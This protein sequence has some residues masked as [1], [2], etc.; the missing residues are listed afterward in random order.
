MEAPEGMGFSKGCYML[1][2]RKFRFLISFVGLLL[3]AFVLCDELFAYNVQDA[4]YQTLQNHPDILS[5]K[6]DS[7]AAEQ[8][9]RV[10]QGGL[11]PSLDVSAGIGRENSNNPATRAARSGTRTMTRREAEAFLQQLVFDG[12]N[13]LST[14]KQR[15]YEFDTSVHRITEI[16]ER[17]A[18]EA[19]SVYLDI[20]R[21]REVLSVR[22]LDV[23]AHRDLVRKVER[24]LAAGAGR[25]S[26]ISL[27][28]ARLALAISRM[29]ATQGALENAHDTFTR[30][31]GHPA[32]RS[33]QNPGEAKNL[34]RSEAEARALGMQMNPS[35]KVTEAQ[36]LSS[37][38]AIGIAESAFYPR[39]TLDF[40]ATYNNNLDGVLGR[41]EDAQAMLRMTYNLLNGGSDLA[42]IRAAK[43]RER[44]SVEEIANIR[45]DVAEDVSIS[46]NDRQTAKDQLPYLKE[47]RD[48]SLEVFNAYVK[49][50]QLGQRT[51]FDLLNSQAEYYDASINY[52][53][54]RYDLRVEGYRLLASIGTLVCT[55]AQGN[56]AI[57]KAVERP[58]D[59][60]TAEGNDTRRYAK[61][62][63]DAVGNGKQG[64]TMLSQDDAPKATTVV[65][66]NQEITAIMGDQANGNQVKTITPDK[67]TSL[68]KKTSSSQTSGKYTLQLYSAANQQAAEKFIKKNHLESDARVVAA[69]VNGKTF[70]RV[71]NGHYSNAS[72]AEHAIGE[73]PSTVQAM[74]PLVRTDTA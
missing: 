46:W 24:R 53:N 35:V 65:E 54:G 40:S 71:L 16:Q 72:T 37:S 25:K 59:Y 56:Y 21:N 9:I 17:L 48:D 61:K 74:H 67:P 2:S 36:A 58:F 13:V 38:A 31:V 42:N 11:Y 23:K 15:R 3:S 5:S 44:A 8:D 55:M 52:I 50:F 60:Q 69:D 66:T 19:V 10:A 33:L 4:V 12:G 43:N 32:P 28:K 51:L 34:P 70:Y 22:R 6:A 63:K 57:E 39:F 73:L 14:V 41:N 18:F 49:Q 27:A 7:A 1:N 30:I 45:R 64:E 26:E 68:A 47:H 62:S 29:E 20:L